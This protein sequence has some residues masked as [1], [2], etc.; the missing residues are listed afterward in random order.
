MTRMVRKGAVTGTQSSWVRETQAAGVSLKPGEVLVPTLLGSDGHSPLSCA[1][2]PLVAGTLQRK[3]VQVRLAPAPRY[4]DPRRDGDITLYMATCPQRDGGTTAIAAGASLGDRVAAAFAQAAVEEWAAVAA[5]RVVLAASTPWCIG[6]LRAAE[7]SRAAAAEHGG[8]GRAVRVLGPNLL[9]AETAAELDMLGAVQ[10]TSLA[11]AQEGDV[12]VF[13][14]HGVSAEIR[15]EA[16]ER[17]LVII[18]ATCPLVARAQ[19]TASRLAARGQHVVLIGQADAAAA[20][21]IA[22]RAA[23]QLTIIENTGGTHT[24]NVRDA[25]RISYLHQPGIP[26]ESA[27]GVA[28]ALESRYPAAR[29]TPPAG[30]CYAP[31]DRLATSRAVAT[32]S[33]L[34][35]VLGDPDSADARQ[36][37]SQARDAGARVQVVGAVFEI[38]PP[39]LAGVT[40]V[41]TIESTSAPAGLAAQVIAAIGG[42]GEL[43]VARRQVKTELPGTE[44]SADGRPDAVRRRSVSGRHQAGLTYRPATASTKAGMA[45][46][47]MTRISR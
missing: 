17:G 44:P 23:G 37:A 3:G 2:A 33:E 16:A 19:E 12:V 14:A 40:T 15:A 45:A 10:V 30:L 32:G 22:S 4:D 38:T 20:G 11:D 34:V 29:A 39:M 35:L 43:I 27:N 42:L 18:D 6:A 26:V 25:Q 8:R 7:R 21:P 47:K 28:S 1:A 46:V 13:P 5:S 41:G 31:S 36:V 24:L 9:P